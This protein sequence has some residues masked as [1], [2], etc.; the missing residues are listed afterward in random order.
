MSV[1]SGTPITQADLD[2]LATLANSI[3]TPAIDQTH[4]FT[5]F[6]ADL[7]PPSAVTG[8]I[9]YGS[10]T[11]LAA[12]VEFIC[13]VYSYKDI[14]GRRHYSQQCAIGHV[15]PNTSL[16]FFEVEWN[17]TAPADP[18]DGYIYVYWQ[19]G[20]GNFVGLWSDVTALPFTDDFSSLTD[21]FSGVYADENPVEGWEVVDST[22]LDYTSG[23][24]FPGPWLRQLN[25]LRTDAFGDLAANDPSWAVSGPWVVAVG[26]LLRFGSDVS[27]YADV[28]FLYAADD[29]VGNLDL[30]TIV[31]IGTSE[32]P[33]ELANASSGTTFQGFLDYDTT[34]AGTVSGT[35]TW[36]L[37]G[38]SYNT[39][40]LTITSGTPTINTENWT[41]NGNTLTLEFDISLPAGVSV[42]RVDVTTTADNFTDP[43]DIISAVLLDTE[44]LAAS[45][46]D[47]IHESS[48][49]K[50][51]VP[52]AM[53]GSLGPVTFNSVDYYLAFRAEGNLEGVWVAKSRPVFGVQTFLQNDLPNYYWSANGWYSS[54]HAEATFNGNSVQPA[55]SP[56]SALWPV[57]RDTDFGTWRNFNNGGSAPIPYWA[58]VD[59]FHSFAQDQLALE[60]GAKSEASSIFVPSN[61]EAIVVKASNASISVYVS[62]VSASID[63]NNAATYDATG[64]GEV[65]LPDDFAWSGNGT[66]W[67][68]FKNTTANA[69]TF[70]AQTVLCLKNDSNI[71]P[72]DA[73]VFF[74]TLSSGLAGFELHSFNWA[75]GT[76][77]SGGGGTLSVPHSG[78]CIFRITITRLPVAGVGGIASA[79]STGTAEIGVSIGVIQGQTF[80]VSGT[81]EQLDT[82]TL[83]ANTASVTQEVFWPVLQGTPLVYQASEQVQVMAFVNFQ[84][85]LHSDFYPPRGNLVS[86][87]LRGRYC[88]E[89]IPNVILGLGTSYFRSPNNLAATDMDRVT[90]P[91][92][93]TLYNDAE[94]ILNL[95]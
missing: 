42:I 87:N 14:S 61:Y 66:L 82:I 58:G 93:A 78:Y 54:D 70:W 69:A 95:L 80:D 40:G 12:G 86:G 55:A 22:R 51:V 17:W 48:L 85:A 27:V 46:T 44:N 92:H 81:F 34:A 76:K 38:S 83:P 77:D 3:G 84:P 20:T 7:Q 56:R 63:P 41:V 79:P 31:E 29:H 49:G 94:D 18:V 33:V 57:F 21:P 45:D 28:E 11:H 24:W 75:P 4:Q 68:L 74:K 50:K 59:P 37:G 23:A 52:T 91:V 36:T 47:V 73:P 9:N 71:Y 25:R 19:G 89:R 6:D 30:D 53:D 60:A 2:A 67:F 1:T 32:V 26:P 13:H 35:I 43:A 88:G 16:D 64:V 90:L 15:Q 72:G 10:G 8:T 39:Y 62:T 65:R 5:Y